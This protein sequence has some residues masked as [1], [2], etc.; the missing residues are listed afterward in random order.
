M[1]GKRTVRSPKAMMAFALTT[2]RVDRSST[3]NSRRIC[4]SHT[5]GL[6]PDKKGHTLKSHSKNYIKSG[7]FVL[8][9]AI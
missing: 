3:V 5:D 2:G 6:T 1:L 8:K 7:Q 9:T 4:S